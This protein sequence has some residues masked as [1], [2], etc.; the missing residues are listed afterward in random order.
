VDWSWTS[1]LWILRHGHYSDKFV[2]TSSTAQLF[3]WQ[4]ADHHR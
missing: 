4:I 3:Y 1:S 2:F